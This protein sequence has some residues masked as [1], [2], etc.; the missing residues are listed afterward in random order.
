MDTDFSV[1]ELIMETVHRSQIVLKVL[2]RILECT[3]VG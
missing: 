2:M 1:E 3:R